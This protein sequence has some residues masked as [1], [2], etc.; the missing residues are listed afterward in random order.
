MIS[1]IESSSI[2]STWRGKFSRNGIDDSIVLYFLY[3]FLEAFDVYYPLGKFWQFI[4]LRN[5]DTN[6]C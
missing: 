5:I 3:I 2:V 4:T 1:F 6:G